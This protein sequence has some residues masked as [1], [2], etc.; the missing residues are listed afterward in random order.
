MNIKTFLV[1]VLLFCQLS[2]PAQLSIAHE[3]PETDLIPEGIAYDEKT[4]D[5]YVGSTWKRKILRIQPNGTVSDFVPSGRDGLL[6]VIGMRVDPKRRLL[7]VATS[8]AGAGMPVQ[9]LTDLAVWKS[10]I[11]KYDLKTG[12]CLRQY[13]LDAPGKSYF[14]NDLTIDQSGRVYATEMMG[15]AIYTIAPGSKKMKGFLQMPDG[16]SPNGIDLDESGK[17]LFV[18]LYLKPRAFAKIEIPTKQL[19]LLNLPSDEVI[20]ADGLY[21][22]Q[23]SLIAVQPGVKDRK[24]TQY[25]LNE[26]HTVIERIRVLLPDDPLL[27]QPTTGAVAGDRFYFIATSQLQ[28]FARHY[29]ENNGQV[30]PEQLLPVLIGEIKL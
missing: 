22:Y 10:G 13:W 4:G 27:A 23:N 5:L 21:F 19:A 9:G 12:K 7:W 24:I 18:S 28:A 25:F 20:G 16:H 6:G 30:A 29:R 3:I 26:D 2:L 17:Q 15:N 8:I 14:L 11:F 1:F